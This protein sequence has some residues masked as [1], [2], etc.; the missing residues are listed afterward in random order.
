MRGSNSREADVGDMEFAAKHVVLK[1]VCCL[2]KNRCCCLLRW[3]C[4]EIP[5]YR[6]LPSSYFVCVCAEC[7]V[8]SFLFMWV[9]R[10]WHV[11]RDDG[12]RPEMRC[13]YSVGYNPFG[14]DQFD[15]KS[16]AYEDTDTATATVIRSFFVE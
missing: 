15:G 14:V 10:C 1:S 6:D 3:S 7:F 4:V 8:R 12:E 13:K 2:Q 11:Y 16:R 5:A 9:L